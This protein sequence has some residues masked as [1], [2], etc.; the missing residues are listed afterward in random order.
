MILLNQSNSNSQN[1]GRKV[2]TTRTS[3]SGLL[4]P[5]VHRMDGDCMKFPIFNGNGLE[6]P[7][8]H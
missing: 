4:V 1:N 2:P 3:N 7:K 8:K 5:Q 6:D